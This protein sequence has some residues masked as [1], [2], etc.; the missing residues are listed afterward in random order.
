MKLAN[1]DGRLVLVVDDGIVDVAEHRP[2]GSRR[3]RSR[4][5]S[6]GT[7]CRLGRAPSTPTGP[8]DEAALLA[9]VP[10]PRQVFAIGLNYAGHAAEAGL[11]IPQFP[12]TFTKFPTCLTGPDAT[13]VLPSEFVDWE[14][15]LVLVIGRLAYE[16]PRATAG[17]TSPV[18]PSARTC[19]SGSSRPARRHRSSAWASRSPGSGRSGR[20]SSPPTSSPTP[21]TS[22]SAAPSTARR[23]RRAARPT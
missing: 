7:S 18:S 14:V 3:T 21:T 5:T 17:R 16:V 2:A 13:V 8:L 20:G 10:R 1:H 11:D 6:D 12:P 19:P 4:S 22:P 15:E 9:P 23:C